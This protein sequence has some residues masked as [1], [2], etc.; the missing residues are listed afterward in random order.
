MAVGLWHTN[1]TN[2]IVLNQARAVRRSARARST[3]SVY[4]V[5]VRVCVPASEAINYIHMKFV[6]FRNV[7]N[8]DM[9]RE[10]GACNYGNQHSYALNLGTDFPTAKVTAM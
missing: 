6:A 7:T 10:A 8:P 5:C 1:L 2:C 4:F 3:N 9:R